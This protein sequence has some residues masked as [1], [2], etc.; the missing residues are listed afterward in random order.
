[1]NTNPWLVV[2]AAASPVRARLICF[3]YAGGGASAFRRWAPLIPAGV[4]LVAVQPPGREARFTETP[5]RALT[6][7][8]AGLREAIAPLL[9]RPTIFFGHS[10]GALVAYELVRMLIA[11]DMPRP[12]HL[13]ASGRRAPG[14]ALG[15][16]AFHD[17]PQAELIEELRAMKG[18]GDG[19]LEHPELMEMLL[20]L[21]RADFEVHDTYRWQPGAPLDLP[22]TALGGLDDVA[23]DVDNLAAWQSMSRQPCR[24]RM[25]RGGHF[26]IDDSRDEVLAVVCQ[27]L[28][29]LIASAVEC[30]GAAA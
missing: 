30:A 25:F 7:L 13:F 17:L 19:V 5:Y 18:T 29:A 3:P 24:V 11:A 8:V 12:A 15:R 2:H 20:P 26:F 1:M 4:E 28:Q 9:D 10:L 14:L 16:R 22:I 23:T 27:E 6:P 21:L